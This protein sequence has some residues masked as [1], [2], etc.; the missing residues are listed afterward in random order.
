M[1]LQNG[2][3][4]Q[5]AGSEAPVGTQASVVGNSSATTG[6]TE[7]GVVGSLKKKSSSSQSIN[8]K[9]FNQPFSSIFIKVK[10]RMAC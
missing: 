2:M 6:T 5:R 3:L 9:Y 1:Y 10:L 7:G 8:G 4:P